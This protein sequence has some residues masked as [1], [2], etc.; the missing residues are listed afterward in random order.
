M[1]QIQ[2]NL[3]VKIHLPR[4]IYHQNE[5]FG[6]FLL[7]LPVHL[8][9]CSVNIIC[10]M[11][12]HCLHN[13]NL[14]SF[15]FRTHRDPLV[16]QILIRL[17]SLVG[18]SHS[19]SI[20]SRRMCCSL[21]HHVIRDCWVPGTWPNS[22]TF[23]S[24]LSAYSLFFCPPPNPIFDIAYSFLPFNFQHKQH[25]LAEAIP[26]YFIYLCHPLHPLCLITSPLLV[27]E[28]LSQCIFIDFLIVSFHY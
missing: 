23:Y 11:N 19:R 25:V 2:S 3:C 15:L 4:H 26:D 14:Y 1:S 20:N 27:W 17:Q 6:V 28:L 7:K 24:V 12:L 9:F 5:T 22:S 16:P 18:I 13:I 8:I 10:L 21:Y